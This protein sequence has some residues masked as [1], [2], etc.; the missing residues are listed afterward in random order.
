MNKLIQLK[1]FIVAIIEKLIYAPTETAKGKHSKVPS[2]HT[3]Q[4]T[5]V[6]NTKLAQPR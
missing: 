1:Q 4:V 2:N 5:D 6:L 3:Q